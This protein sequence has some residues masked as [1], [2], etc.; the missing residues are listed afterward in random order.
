MIRPKATALT[1]R[2]AS[3][4]PI[5]ANPKADRRMGK[6]GGWYRGSKPVKSR[7][8]SPALRLAATDR[9]STESGEIV[10]PYVEVRIKTCTAPR[11]ATRM[12]RREMLF[13][14]CMSN[15]GRNAVGGCVVAAAGAGLLASFLIN[16]LTAKPSTKRP[17]AGAAVAGYSTV[18]FPAS[19]IICSASSDRF[20][21]GPSSLA[22][23]P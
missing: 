10:A 14:R 2:P 19:L 11:T 21:A 6:K 16:A 17:G 3:A 12:V 18:T 15:V 8:P 22:D 1:S 5:P 9:Y 7:K 13:S 4:G 20:L 23:T